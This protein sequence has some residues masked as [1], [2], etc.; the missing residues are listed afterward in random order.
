M[1]LIMPWFLPIGA[2]I[3]WLGC[4]T[5]QQVWNKGDTSRTQALW[6]IILMLFPLFCWLM[7]QFISPQGVH[8]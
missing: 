1:H 3:A 7:T 5:S 8:P 6:L 2:F 4:R